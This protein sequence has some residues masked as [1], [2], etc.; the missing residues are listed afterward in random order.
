M[1][2]SIA[3]GNLTS[4]IPSRALGLLSSGRIIGKEISEVP[5]NVL[6][7]LVAAGLAL[8]AVIFVA[9]TGMWPTE[10]CQSTAPFGPHDFSCTYTLGR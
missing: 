4:N 10:R 9:Q 8:G 7:V 6:A 5:M 3:E 1:L 2:R